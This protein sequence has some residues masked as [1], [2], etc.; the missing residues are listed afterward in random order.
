M[1]DNVLIMS[2][3]FH[4]REEVLL[5]TIVLYLM[6]TLKILKRFKYVDQQTYAMYQMGLNPDLYLIIQL[7]YMNS[8]FD[9]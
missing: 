4:R 2:L 6:K 5:L 7:L 8:L 3:H 9:V 1:V